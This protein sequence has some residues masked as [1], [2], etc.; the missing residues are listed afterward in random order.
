MESMNLIK[1]FW[2]ANILLWAFLF[3]V[4]LLMGNSAVLRK[5][6]YSE[7]YISFMKKDYTVRALTM[8]ILI[9][10]IQVASY[11]IVSL[12]V[13]D[14]S[15]KIE[16]VLLVF[17]IMIIPF[18][19]IDNTITR[20]K[21]K[22]IKENSN[23]IM[24]IDFKHKILNLIFNPTIEMVLTV[25]TV[26]YALI[27]IKPVI[28]FYLHIILPWFIYATARKSQKTIRPHLKDGYLWTFVFITINF[29]LILYYILSCLIRGEDYMLISETSL[30][31][32]L[33]IIL[34]SRIIYYLINYP[35]LR[36]KLQED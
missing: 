26:L 8:S 34:S 14:V 25:I 9:P 7:D 36:Q 1:L 30:G 15:S 31:V 5:R 2:I 17:I 4:T 32:L 21:L 16:I 24:V 12:F 23:N 27:V 33:V 28:L 19:I 29:A 13:E 6:G 22:T 35:R 10:V 11:F 3:I 18:P 20:G